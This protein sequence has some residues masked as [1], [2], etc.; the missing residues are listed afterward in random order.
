MIS[1]IVIYCCQNMKDLCFN[2]SHS[3]YYSAEQI[4]FW[5][6]FLKPPGLQIYMLMAKVVDEDAD[7]GE[8]SRI[9]VSSFSGGN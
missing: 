5:Q 6:L 4:S 8:N 1:A 9:S 3:N 7:M 2:A